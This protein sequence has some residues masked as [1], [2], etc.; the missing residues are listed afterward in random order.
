MQRAAAPPAS[1]VLIHDGAKATPHRGPASC[2]VLEQLR[3]TAVISL[4]E[5]FEHQAG[6]KLGLGVDF[7]AELVG[8]RA[9]GGLGGVQGPPSHDQ[10]RFA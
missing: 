7:G 4:E 3:H 1:F 10:R 8:V 9:Q 6:E 2:L 5:D